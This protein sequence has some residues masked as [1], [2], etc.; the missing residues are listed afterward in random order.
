MRYAIVGGGVSGLTLGILLAQAGEECH[1]FE[2]NTTAGGNLCGWRRGA[3]EIDNCC[4]WLSG[5]LPASARHALWERLG[6]LGSGVSVY[7]PPAFYTSCGDGESLSLWADVS[8]ARAECL[9]YSAADAAPIHR[10]FD[11]AER[12]R[13]A[14]GAADDVPLGRYLW[15]QGRRLGA[16]VRYGR[17][18]LG[19]IAQDFRAPLLRRLMCDYFTPRFCGAG[20]IL[21]YGAFAAGDGGIPAGGS[22]AMAQ[23]MT[24]TFLRAGGQLHTGVACIGTLSDPRGVRALRLLACT[25]GEAQILPPQDTGE[26]TLHFA[27][28]FLFACDPS[29]VYGN[30]LPAPMPPA[31]TRRY[32]RLAIA[33]SEHAAFAADAS[34]A[35]F[36]GSRF[37]RGERGIIG[38]RSYRYEPSFAPQGRVVLQTMRLFASDESEWQQLRLQDPDAYRREKEKMAQHARLVL[39][40]A[41]SDAGRSAQLL[42]TWTPA[43]YAR[44][45]GA[46]DGGYMGFF[47]PAGLLPETLAPE[48]GGIPNA[49][50]VGQWQSVFGGLPTAAAHAADL[51]VRLGASV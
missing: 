14:V 3:Y 2:R 32:R 4:H 40:E 46:L 26:Q 5:T 27:D 34:A 19:E 21:A 45:T 49:Y 17:R 51:A 30:L 33:T 15:R 6:V 1:L 44:Y 8:R 23:R 43:T 31:L 50:V 9:A 47:H 35:D 38:V 10:F 39:G 42:D 48:V 20:L 37:Y 41:L 29:L 22:R 25:E 11:A 7:R 28:R 16:L 13:D 12:V 36:D 24:E 18:S